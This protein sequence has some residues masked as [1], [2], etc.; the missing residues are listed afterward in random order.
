M[1]N[2]PALSQALALFSLKTRMAEGGRL[3]PLT[4]LKWSKFRLLFC[5]QS[6]HSVNKVTF[7]FRDFPMDQAT[8]DARERP[9]F[10]PTTQDFTVLQLTGPYM[11]LSSA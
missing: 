8:P 5:P 1:P 10:V 2:R 11:D 6:F 3:W 9:Q 7:L 4:A